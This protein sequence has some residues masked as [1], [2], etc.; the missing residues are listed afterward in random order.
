MIGFLDL[1]PE[2]RNIIYK[3]SRL[4]DV[5]NPAML[6]VCRKVNQEYNSTALAN[7]TFRDFN[8]EEAFYCASVALLK[9]PEAYAPFVQNVTVFIVPKS[10]YRVNQYQNCSA[11]TQR[12]TARGFTQ[13]LQRLTTY[14]A[15]I[16][17]TF[18]LDQS[19]ELVNQG[20]PDRNLPL[21]ILEALRNM[22]AAKTRTRP[23][24]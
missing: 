23:V 9:T 2:I 21:E 18:D 5:G 14:G 12:I 16:S 11:E 22:L 8:G 20:H 6:R 1:P 19:N 7:L 3:Q 24:V 17:L 4:Y 10:C 13:A 15:L